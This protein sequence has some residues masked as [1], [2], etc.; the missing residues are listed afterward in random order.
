M[1]TPGIVVAPSEPMSKSKDVISILASH[2]LVFAVVGHVGSGTSTVANTLRQALEDA[3]YDVALIKARE[4]I[5]RWCQR[6]SRPISTDDGSIQRS[7]DLQ[8]AGDAMRATG[9]FAAVAA[10]MVGEI[11]QTRAKRTNQ[12]VV[13]GRAV[14]PDGA[15]RAY[16]L[17]SIRHPAEVELLRR[18]YGPAFALVGVVCQ[19]DRR[20]SRL[21]GKYTHTGKTDLVRFMERDAK[22]PQKHGQRVSDGYHMSDYFVDNTDN[23]KLED[24]RPNPD[25]LILEQVSRLLKIIEHRDIQRPFVDE[26]RCSWPMGRD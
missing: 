20:L 11:R 26:P 17:D 16:V 22:A 10:G 18:L 8:D 12:E 9:D 2:E 25:W 3:G 4:V 1:S 24:G 15:H 13:D 7:V 23:R 6:N 5:E 14:L 19:E 21:E